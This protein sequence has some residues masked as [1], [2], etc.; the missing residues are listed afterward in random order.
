MLPRNATLIDGQMADE[1][2]EMRA[3][4]A[5]AESTT[6]VHIVPEHRAVDDTP[7]PDHEGFERVFALTVAALQ[8]RIA[9][10]RKRA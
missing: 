2:R 6:G 8:K 9:K 5:T 3:G 4:A 10:R 1:P 7:P